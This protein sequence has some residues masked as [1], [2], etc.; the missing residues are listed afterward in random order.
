MDISDDEIKY[1]HGR[2]MVKGEYDP[3]KKKKFQK[4]YEQW[5]REAR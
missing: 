2:K 1:P 4:Q 3:E 5:E